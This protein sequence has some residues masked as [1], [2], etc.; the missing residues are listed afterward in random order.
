MLYIALI[1]ASLQSL[2]TSNP[3]SNF[4]IILMPEFPETSKLFQEFLQ[5]K[6]VEK[7][8]SRFCSAV[9]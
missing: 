6:M 9:K 2:F 7:G 1:K 5:G 3:E 4:I 8:W